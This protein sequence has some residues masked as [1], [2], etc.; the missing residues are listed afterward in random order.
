VEPVT[1]GTGLKS[2]VASG[3]NS[4]WYTKYV[5]ETPRFLSVALTLP[6]VIHLRGIELGESCS[7]SP[8]QF[9]GMLGGSTVVLKGANMNISVVILSLRFHQMAA[10][11]KPL[12][13]NQEHIWWCN[14]GQSSCFCKQWSCNKGHSAHSV[15]S[16]HVTRDTVPSPYTVVK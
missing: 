2:P 1:G 11:I 6:L 14:K 8:L 16:G 7:C 5:R 15:H 4:L 10:V 12:S 3:C 9:H 13:H